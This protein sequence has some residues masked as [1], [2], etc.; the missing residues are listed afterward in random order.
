MVA[1]TLIYEA[2]MSNTVQKT[3]VTL[4][5]SIAQLSETLSKA[6]NTIET[7]PNSDINTLLKAYQQYSDQLDI[8]DSIKKV[9]DEAYRHLA[10]ERLPKVF[11]DLGFDSVKSGGRNF[12][13]SSQLFASIPSDKQ[14][15][16]FK[17]LKTNNLDALIKPTVNPRALSSA[18]TAY[19]EENAMEPPQEAMTL[20]K[21]RKIS[22]R[23]SG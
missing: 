9:A 13:L 14:E 23:K 19:I 22:I 17:W 15:I 21:K 4:S 7:I 6:I 20:Y 8:L 11:E 10:E 12:I 1:S 18:I 3:E 16:G 5:K 2:V